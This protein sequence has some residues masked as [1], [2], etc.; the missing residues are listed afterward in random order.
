MRSV[1]VRLHRYIGLTIAAFL[2]VASLTGAVL[3]WDQELDEWINRDF[4]TV[5]SNGPYRSPHDLAQL[6]EAREPR[7][8]VTFMPLY[9]EPGRNAPFTVRPRTNPET[10]EAFALDYTHVFVDPVTGVELGRRDGD[11]N[12]LS[13]RSLMPFLIKLHYS[14]HIPLT[15]SGTDLGSWLLG[16]IALIWFINSLVA[17]FLT[18]PPKRRAPKAP[19][20]TASRGW[21]RRWGAS[22]KIRWRGGPATVNFDLHRAGALWIWPALLIVAFTGFTQNLSTD[23]FQPAISALSKPTPGPYD[24]R[25]PV[26]DPNVGPALRS[27]EIAGRARAEATRLGWNEPAYSMSF[28]PDFNIYAVHFLHPK[29]DIGGADISIKTLYLD[30]DDGRVFS[31]RTP[32][33]GTAADIIE[34]MQFPVHSGR[35]FGLLGQIFISFLGLMVAMLS[36]TGILI[37]ARKRRFAR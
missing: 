32:L 11:G 34:K 21:W 10:G 13:W 25:A 18:F 6:I 22:W 20:A 8:R 30:G 31:L 36:V 3:S 2:I 15:A 12:T 23:V 33:S 29:D 19:Q 35:L 16:L 9:F 5:T 1:L 14:L 24:T 28:S 37:W 17:I 27:S 7:G 4:F 26:P